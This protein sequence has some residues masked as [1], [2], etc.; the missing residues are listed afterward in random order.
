MSVLT[1]LE[2][3]L[4]G[5]GKAPISVAP[6]TELIKDRKSVGI[7]WKYCMT[8]RKQTKKKSRAAQAKDYEDY[9]WEKTEAA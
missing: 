4:K 5:W 8:N 3:H 2:G 9:G 1:G 7:V 6:I